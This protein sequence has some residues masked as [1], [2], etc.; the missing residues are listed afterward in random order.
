MNS[1][2]LRLG[3]AS[4]ATGLL[5]GGTGCAPATAKLALWEQDAAPGTQRILVISDIHLGVDDAFGETVKNKNLLIDFLNRASATSINQIVIAGDF[6]DEWYLPAN[7]AA[8]EDSAAFYRKVKD[9][10]AEVFAAL[11]KVMAAG[12]TLSYVPGNHDLLLDAATLTELLPGIKQARDADGLGALRTGAR[13]EVLIEHGHR[14][15]GGAAPDSL[16]NQE[17][18]GTNR[19]IL[20]MGY[21]ATTMIVTSLA[22]GKSA[23]KE[24][25]P[26]IPA[27]KNPTEEQLGA[28]AYYLLWSKLMSDYPISAGWDD[29]VFDASFAGYKKPVSLRDLFPV[30]R[31]DGSISAPLF[32]DLQSRWE[33]LQKANGVAKPNPFSAAVTAAFKHEFLDQQA[34]RQ[35]FEVEPGT[36]VVVFGHSHVPVLSR[37]TQGYDRPKTY[38]NSGTW[39]DHNLVGVHTGTFVA[40][41]SGPQSTDVRVLKYVDDG[42]AEAVANP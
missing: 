15:D 23:P 26:M 30:Q 13:S 34:I 1:R 31:A 18:T 19:S 28:Y 14:Y 3:V 7:R 40:I 17:L 33:Q 20:P 25:L 16:S 27:P 8:H 11:A 35:R 5:V 36:D 39:I 6:L 21:F 41:E 24:A 4:A 37:T 38:A 22:E 32:P 42:K 29:P 9:N 12:V 10:N 2:W